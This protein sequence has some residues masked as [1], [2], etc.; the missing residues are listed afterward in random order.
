MSTDPLGPSQS[1]L[2]NQ[3]QSSKVVTM[4]DLNRNK[5]G[6]SCAKLLLSWA[7]LAPRCG[8]QVFQIF[9]TS[10]I[11]WGPFRVY[12]IILECKFS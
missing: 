11:I 6:L 7:E 5:L 12:Q 8:L 10:N 4:F 3:A 2:Y 1:S 9:Q